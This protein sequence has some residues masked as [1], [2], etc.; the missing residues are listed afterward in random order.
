MQTVRH[1]VFIIAPVKLWAQLLERQIEH[2]TDFEVIGSARDG[3]GALEELDRLHPSS[4]I[5]V[6]DINTMLALQAAA[7]LRRSHPSLKLVAIGLDDSPGQALAWASAGA[8]GLLGRITTQEELLGT[9]ADVAAGG[10]HCSQ[11]ISG[12][13]LRGIGDTEGG[14]RPSASGAPLTRREREVAQL[15]AGGFTNKEIAERLHVSAGTVKSH[16]HNVIHKLG[17]ARRA[18]V[19]ASLPECPTT[20]SLSQRADPHDRESH[21]V[22]GQKTGNGEPIRQLLAENAAFR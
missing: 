22:S 8:V 20:P 4:C 3:D 14:V 11:D 9:L 16:V 2:L 21:I 18:H 15:V 1:N 7:A 6:V 19:A 10:T 5:V 13:L 17:I 12:A